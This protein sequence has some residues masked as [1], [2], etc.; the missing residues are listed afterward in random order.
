MSARGRDEDIPRKYSKA[1]QH[2]VLPKTEKKMKKIT[3]R[4]QITSSI[5]LIS[6]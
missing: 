1:E 3:A 2:L 5:W 4:A 6:L